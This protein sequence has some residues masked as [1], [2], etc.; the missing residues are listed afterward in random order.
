MEGCHAPLHS[1]FGG[2]PGFRSGGLLSFLA[3]YTDSEYSMAVMKRF[4]SVAA[5]D[6][7]LQLL[8]LC[9][10]KLDQRAAAGATPAP[11][12]YPGHTPRRGR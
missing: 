1:S 11:A 6:L 8:D 5:N 7:I 2:R 12:K 10:V 9:I 4:E 3:V